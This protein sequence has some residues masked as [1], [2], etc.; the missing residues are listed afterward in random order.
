MREKD[1]ARIR[2]G[3]SVAYKSH[4]ETALHPESI[5]LDPEKDA[6]NRPQTPGGELTEY[7]PKEKRYGCSV[8]LQS[9]EFQDQDLQEPA[10][11]QARPDNAHSPTGGYGVS[12]RVKGPPEETHACHHQEYKIGRAHV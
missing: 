3:S 8:H 12:C 2:L 9:T 7:Q 4:S 11:E 6:H 5:G 1:A 10:N